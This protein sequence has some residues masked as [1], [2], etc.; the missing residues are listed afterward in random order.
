MNLIKTKYKIWE[1]IITIDGIIWYVHQIL[2]DWLVKYNIFFNKNEYCVLS[3]YQ[4]MK[5]KNKKVK[6]IW[7]KTE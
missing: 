6:K 1:K 2:F 7:F 5:K 4:I 3:E